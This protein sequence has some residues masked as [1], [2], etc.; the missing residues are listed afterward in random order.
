[1]VCP[2]ALWSGMPVAV[3]YEQALTVRHT[4]RPLTSGLRLSRLSG[5]H[6]GYSCSGSQQ[7]RDMHQPVRTPDAGQLQCVQRGGDRDGPGQW[8]AIQL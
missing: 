1:M 5:T 3:T 6:N 7:Q 2:V 4:M 8:T